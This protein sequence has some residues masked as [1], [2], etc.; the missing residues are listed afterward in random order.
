MMLMSSE[1]T[2]QI[3]NMKANVNSKVQT[4]LCDVMHGP[5]SVNSMME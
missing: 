2:V 1:V 5:D 4:L 3:S